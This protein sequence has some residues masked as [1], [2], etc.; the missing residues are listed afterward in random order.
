MRKLIGVLSALVGFAAFM[1]AVWVGCGAFLKN[2]DAY[3]RGLETA[4]NDP[5]VTDLLGAPV[6][7]SWFLNGSIEGGGG[8]SRGVWSTRLRGT[9]RSGTLNIV[10]FKRGG[11][12]GVVSMRLSVGEAFYAYLPGQGF[13]R[14]ADDERPDFDILSLRRAGRG[15]IP[16]SE[17][18]SWR[19][20]EAV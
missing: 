13:V 20:L 4:L 1:S 19:H 2:N 9:E 7:E 18:A 5:T 11:A 15:L 16:G 3:E 6:V 14:E 12:W 10:G 8:E 17:P